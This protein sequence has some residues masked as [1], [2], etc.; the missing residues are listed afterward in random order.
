ML[1]IRLWAG[2]E[3]DGPCLYSV[4]IPLPGP[5]IPV[6]GANQGADSA[7]QTPFGAQSTREMCISSVE[8]CASWRTQGRVPMRSS[9]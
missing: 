1:T 7:K 8:V 9:P 2:P 5:F 4:P 3:L 6:G